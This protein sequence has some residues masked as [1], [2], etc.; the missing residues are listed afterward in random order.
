LVGR[1]SIDSDARQACLEM[2]WNDTDQGLQSAADIEPRETVEVIPIA[3]LAAGRRESV[4]VI[5]GLLVLGAVVGVGLWAGEASVP[6]SV[7]GSEASLTTSGAT[8]GADPTIDHP[9]APS[10]SSVVVATPPQ[11][12]I[13]LPAADEVILGSVIVVAGRVG[14]PRP[15]PA[16]LHPSVLHVA[17]INGDV[18][19]GSLQVLERTRGQV[20]IL[21]V[22]DRQRPDR[23][24]IEQRFVLGPGH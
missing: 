17:V 11:I 8:S 19:V 16:Q 23:I 14:D 12:V 10:A 3:P 13:L 24:L 1:W 9:G 15:G 2:R 7:S 18:V 4:T 20:V 5:G 21:R 22:S 6:R